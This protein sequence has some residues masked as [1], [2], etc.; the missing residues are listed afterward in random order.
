MTLELTFE[1]IYL[2]PRG[3]ACGFFM[4]ELRAQIIFG[5]QHRAPDI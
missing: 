5:G 2:T 3:F 4:V 1:K